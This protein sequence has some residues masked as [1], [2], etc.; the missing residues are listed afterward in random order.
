M[1]H[2]VNKRCKTFWEETL[3]L[4][5]PLPWWIW[6]GISLGKKNLPGWKG[7]DIFK[8]CLRLF[9]YLTKLKID[10]RANSSVL[11]RLPD[12]KIKIIGCPF[13]Y[14]LNNFFSMSIPHTLFGSCP[15]HYLGRVPTNIIVYRKHR[16]K[17]EQKAILSPLDCIWERYYTP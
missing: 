2:K 9:R 1:Y 8:I 17:T 15:I 12:L 7:R 3:P 13:K 16:W 11:I 4:Q 14:D 6:G 5:I 10:G